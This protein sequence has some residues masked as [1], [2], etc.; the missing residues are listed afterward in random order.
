L[1]DSATNSKETIISTLY[2]KKT[3]KLQT[4]HGRKEKRKDEEET[5]GRT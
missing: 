3:S 4:K 5:R 1:A 2:R